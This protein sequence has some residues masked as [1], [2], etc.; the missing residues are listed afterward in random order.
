[1][2]TISLLILWS[3][4]KTSLGQSIVKIKGAFKWKE[5]IRLFIMLMV[6]VLFAMVK[7]NKGREQPKFS[8]QIWVFCNYI[9]NFIYHKYFFLTQTELRFRHTENVNMQ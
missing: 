6:Q 9:S 4:P 7:G 3:K 1:M 8:E 2:D 5:G